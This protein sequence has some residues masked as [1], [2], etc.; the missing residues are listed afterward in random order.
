MRIERDER[1]VSLS[2]V[3]KPEPGILKSKS[4][5]SSQMRGPR[6]SCSAVEQ[7]TF[8]TMLTPEIEIVI[9]FIVAIGDRAA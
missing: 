2:G 4:S 6:H 7:L 5:Q 3:L 9:P 1:V 8:A